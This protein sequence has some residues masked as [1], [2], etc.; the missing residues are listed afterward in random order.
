MVST[1]NGPVLP[2][3]PLS[4]CLF[5]ILPISLV[6]CCPFSL[7]PIF[8][9]P[10][11]QP[12]GQ[13]G[14]TLQSVTIFINIYIPLLC[15]PTCVFMFLT[16]SWAT[17]STCPSPFIEEILVL[18]LGRRCVVWCPWGSWISPGGLKELLPK[19]VYSFCVGRF[20]LCAGAFVLHVCCCVKDKGNIYCGCTDCRQFIS[21]IITCLIIEEK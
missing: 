10:T 13:F 8:P 12:E 9:S 17:S 5:L 18:E 6:L 15:S 16:P 7:H 1:V 2:L 11:V 14:N 3:N 20:M 21:G 4:V 19:C